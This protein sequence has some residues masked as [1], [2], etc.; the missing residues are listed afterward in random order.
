MLATLSV[1]FLLT[2]IAFAMISM[3]MTLRESWSK[4]VVALRGVEAAPVARRYR[5][6]RVRSSAGRADPIGGYSMR[7]AA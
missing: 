6:K 1:L 2:A 3:A 5:V 4:V 7:A